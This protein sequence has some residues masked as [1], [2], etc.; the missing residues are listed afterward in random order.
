MS[1]WK[2]SDDVKR[3]LYGSMESSKRSKARVTF[4]LEYRESMQ[5]DDTEPAPAPDGDSS[6]SRD[7]ASLIGDVDWNDVDAM[8]MSVSQE[9]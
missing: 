1:E 9:S 4:D 5:I 8:L 2:L 3:I 7:T 6:G